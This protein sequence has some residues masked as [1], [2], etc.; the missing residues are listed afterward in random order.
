MGKVST[1]DLAVIIVYV[2]GIVGMGCWFVRREKTTEDFF[3]AGR[4]LP[5]WA[6][7]LSIFGT[8]LSA[9]TFIAIPGRA[10][11]TNWVW[12]V[13]N[14]MIPLMAPLIAW[15]FLPFFR[16]TPITSAYEYLEKRFHP[17]LRDY[18]AV[19]FILMQLGRMGIVLYLPAM[20]LAQVTGVS[21][22]LMVVIVGVLII[23][24]TVMGGMEA[25]V[26]TD[27]AQVVILLGGAVFSVFLIAGRLDGG[28][29]EI[30][31]VGA[32]N[33]KFAMFS[34]S[35]SP[36]TTALWLVI[37]GKAFE[38][39]IPYGSDQTVIQRYLTTKTEKDARRS[40]LL[41]AGMAIPASF[42]FFV[43]GSALFVF[44]T[45][46]PDPTVTGILDAAGGG[47]LKQV[48]RIYPLF[49]VSHLPKGIAG[50]VLAAVFAASMSSLDSSLNST[51]TVCVNDL[52]RRYLSPEASE[53]RCLVVARLL[54]VAWGVV[55]TAIAAYI[56]VRSQND[57]AYK[58]AWH[59][60]VVMQGLLGGGLAGLFVLGIF[61]KRA[62]WQGA[63]AGVVYATGALY[64]AKNMSV[65]YLSLG[66]VASEAKLHE[67]SYPLIA[68][69]TCVVFGAATSLLFK[70][71]RETA[72]YTWAGLRRA[73]KAAALLDASQEETEDS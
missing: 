71:R 5:W 2:L 68:I 12:L 32:E 23:L 13:G 67:F 15:V 29:G 26:W 43:L 61:I 70:A 35:W 27:V 72:A 4:R 55:A 45:A 20:A 33:H 21:V 30:L 11:A 65:R 52:Y 69:L 66:L 10:C 60:F 16:R 3:L 28:F 48:D 57:P 50:L 59:M 39:L 1:V 73:D 37:F 22:V 47:D 58:G 44:Y 41:S 36:L 63:V 14:L 18:G 9:I 34:R 19:A 64:L 46:N 40:I 25:V 62:T 49:I 17:R 51:A 42:L 54:T 56:A 38:Q 7:G 31:R 6:V 24:Y 53:R 8:Q